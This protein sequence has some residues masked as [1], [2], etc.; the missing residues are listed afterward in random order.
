M[1]QYFIESV[2][3][4]IICLVLHLDGVDLLAEGVKLRKMSVPDP[5]PNRS[6][7]VLPVDGVVDNLPQVLLSIRNGYIAPATHHK[8]SVRHLDNSILLLF[9]T[10]KINFVP[11]HLWLDQKQDS[12]P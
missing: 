10:K 5:T 9:F 7:R 3:Q 11:K 1:I 6:T 12:N 2:V 4:L 8:H